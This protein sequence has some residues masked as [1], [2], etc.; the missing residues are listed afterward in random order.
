MT[1]AARSC[2]TLDLL[3]NKILIN[4]KNKFKKM[5]KYHQLDFFFFNQS[6]STLDKTIP[7]YEY[8]IVWY[9]I[10]YGKI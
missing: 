3:A 7:H 1:T 8:V 4:N 5:Q 9:C 6:L 10:R 2:H